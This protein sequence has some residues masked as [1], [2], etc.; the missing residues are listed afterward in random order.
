M[1]MKQS[2]KQLEEFLQ[3]NY[4]NKDSETMSVAIRDLLTDL[5]HIGEKHKVNVENRLR[6]AREVHVEERTISR[7]DWWQEMLKY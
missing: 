1:G 6:D 5:I 4:L 2:T 7:S 3:Q